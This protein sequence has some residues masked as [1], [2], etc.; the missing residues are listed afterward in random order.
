MIQKHH[1]TISNSTKIHIFFVKGKESH[2]CPICQETL[3]GYDCKLRHVIHSYCTKKTYCHSICCGLI[4]KTYRQNKGAIYGR[5]AEQGQCKKAQTIKHSI[6]SLVS[7]QHLLYRKRRFTKQHLKRFKFL[8]SSNQHPTC[9]N[10]ICS[11][12]FRELK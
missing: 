4:L 3:S 1:D 8:V 2:F 12:I 11:I 5:R 9:V 10:C 6:Y 7:I